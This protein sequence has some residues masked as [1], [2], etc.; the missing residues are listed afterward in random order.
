MTCPSSDSRSASTPKSSSAAATRSANS[1]EQVGGDK[2]IAGYTR[3]A[4]IFP[5]Q[6][7]RHATCLCA[8]VY[9]KRVGRLPGFEYKGRFAYFLTLCVFSRRARF[10]D[11]RVVAATDRAFREGAERWAFQILAH[12]YMPDHLHLLLQ[13]TTAG[14]DLIRF[15]NGAKQRSGYWHV[16]EYGL[17]LWQTGW[18]DHILRDDESLDRHVSYTLANPV[19]AGLVDRWED[20]PYSGAMVSVAGEDFQ[21]T[22]R[23]QG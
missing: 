15:V 10:S 21:R 7:R 2:R 20:W 19:R 12:C 18:F 5:L 1:A 6:R 16:R 8:C 9:P 13:G 4:P 22:L 11:P 23:T 14:S 3:I 17:P